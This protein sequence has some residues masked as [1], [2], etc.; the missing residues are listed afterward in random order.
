[1]DYGSISKSE[2][3][4]ILKRL[5]SRYY[6]LEETIS[7][8]FTYSTAHIGGRQVRKD[9]DMLNELKAEIGRIEVILSRMDA[10]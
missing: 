8:N 1:M 5:K 9:V 10:P 6:D 4:T 3:E 7:F 2:L